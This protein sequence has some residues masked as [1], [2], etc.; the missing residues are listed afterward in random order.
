VA[1][2]LGMFFV[3]RKRWILLL[4]SFVIA[5][6]M[7]SRMYLAHHFLG[8]ILG[9]LAIGLAVL[10]LLAFLVKKVVF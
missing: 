1:L 2:W 10:A 6:T 3:F 4:G 7:L 5:L 9:G 8:D